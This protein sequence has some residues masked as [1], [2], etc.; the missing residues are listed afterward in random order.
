MPWMTVDAFVKSSLEVGR[1]V[2][3]K[4]RT[5][6]NVGNVP[7]FQLS[8]RL[9]RLLSRLAPFQV[10]PASA[11]RAMINDVTK[12][13]LAKREK[14]IRKSVIPRSQ[15]LAVDMIRALAGGGLLPSYLVGI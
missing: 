3:M 2:P 15:V 7:P 6:G 4:L 10:F 11:G 9:Q 12:R 8:D 13:R 1:S 14:A 5:A